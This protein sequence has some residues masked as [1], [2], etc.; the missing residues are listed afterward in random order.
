MTTFRRPGRTQAGYGKGDRNLNRALRTAPS[1]E[2]A[3]RIARADG[4]EDARDARKWLVMRS[5]RGRE[6]R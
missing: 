4:H 1:P 2:D 3:D 5:R 6:S